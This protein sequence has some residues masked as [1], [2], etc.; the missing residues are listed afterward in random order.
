MKLTVPRDSFL[1][2]VSEVKGAA[3]KTSTWELLRHLRLDAKANTLKVTGTDLALRSSAV[4]D[5]QVEDPGSVCLPVD[6]LA[7]F[8]AKLP[9]GE[10]LTLKVG[11]SYQTE[12]TQGKSK[13][14][15]PGVSAE[16]YPQEKP[17]AKTT[18]ATIKAEDLREM[19]SGVLHCV[20]TEEKL[21]QHL[22]GARLETK[23][24][25]ATTISLDGQRLAV[26]SRTCDLTALGLTDGMTLPTRSV[27]AALVWLKGVEGEVTLTVGWRDEALLT[28]LSLELCS[29]E[30]SF[31][32]KP[33]DALF[34]DWPQVVPKEGRFTSQATVRRAPL[35]EAVG[36][37]LLFDHGGRIETFKDNPRLQISVGH[38]GE[39]GATEEIAIELSGPPI[40]LGLDLRF[41]RDALGSLDCEQIEIAFVDETSPLVITPTEDPGHFCLIMPMRL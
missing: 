22:C 16:D 15:L 13:G 28:A 18:T 35:V 4:C 33:I 29:G 36:R 39:G 8:L 10:T 17:W 34:P 19:L 40:V 25:K 23:D 1:T 26:V 9:K 30:N 20:S 12:I 27:E 2:A 6:L 24:G 21:R 32:L 3:D 38:P 37:L 31:S 11:E 41:L 14:K 5:A 7:K